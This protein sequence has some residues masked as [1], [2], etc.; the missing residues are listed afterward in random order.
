MCVNEYKKIAT[1]LKESLKNAIKLTQFKFDCV[2]K[3]YPIIIE[4]FDSFGEINV[5]FMWETIGY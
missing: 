1:I 3:K 4:L 5:D 2:K